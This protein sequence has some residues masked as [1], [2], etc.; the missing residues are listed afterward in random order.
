MTSKIDVYAYYQGDYE[1]REHIHHFQTG[2]IPREG[3]TL[4]FV[5][6]ESSEGDAIS[7]FLVQDVIY[8][9]E[10]A[11]EEVHLIVEDLDE[12][13]EGEEMQMNPLPS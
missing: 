11:N 13:E 5:G 7:E 2:H 10:N 9:Y 3:E 1:N 4:N 8:Q 12:E 6:M